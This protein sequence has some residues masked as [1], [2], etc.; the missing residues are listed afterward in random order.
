MPKPNR[1]NMGPQMFRIL[2]VISIFVFVTEALVS[3]MLRKPL[4]KHN[5]QAIIFTCTFKIFERKTGK[6]SYLNVYM[7]LSTQYHTLKC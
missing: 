5:L 6:E 2:L 4:F 1:L 3:A 7:S